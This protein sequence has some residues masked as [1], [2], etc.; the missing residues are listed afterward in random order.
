VSLDEPLLAP[1]G[2]LA[3]KLAPV[4]GALG[5]AWGLLLILSVLPS[6]WERFDDNEPFPV[7]ELGG[8]FGGTKPVDRELL[9]PLAG[10]ERAPSVCRGMWFDRDDGALLRGSGPSNGTTAAAWLTLTTGSHVVVGRVT[11]D[12]WNVVGMGTGGLESVTNS[13][14]AHDLR[15]VE[16]LPPPPPG[17]PGWRVIRPGE[18]A[19]GSTEPQDASDVV[20]RFLIDLPA[21]KSVDVY[22]TSELGT[23]NMPLHDALTLDGHNL[24]RSSERE[25]YWTERDGRYEILVRAGSPGDDCTNRK[26]PRAYSLEVEWGKPIAGTCPTP[27]DRFD[28][29]G[30][31]QP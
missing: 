22:I 18:C 2:R 6:F 14:I 29:F 12:L 15:L 17:P 24:S 27:N 13:I 30:K 28:C 26:P 25:R 11:V 3:T 16:R 1:V 5:W 8:A 23:C 31:A 20:G 21:R 10:H 19:L 9:G 7:R 4:V